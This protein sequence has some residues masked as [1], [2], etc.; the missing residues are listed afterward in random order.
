MQLVV[1]GYLENTDI[2]EAS[3]DAPQ[4]LP[5]TRPLK[6][7]GPLMLEVSELLDRL[8]VNVRR[9]RDFDSYV[10]KHEIYPLPIWLRHRAVR[11]DNE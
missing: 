5:F 4:M 3:Y 11:P 9:N 2:R 1:A 8:A 7:G 10:K 6:V